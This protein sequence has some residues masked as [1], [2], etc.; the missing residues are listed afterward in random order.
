MLSKKMEN[1]LNEQVN[2]ELFSAYLYLSMV[3]YFVSLG[4]PGFAQWMRVQTQEELFHG[5]KMY[6]H[7]NQ[8]GGRVILRAIDAPVAEWVAPL[9]A[10]E[11]AYDHEK[12]I[13][14]SINKL[15]DLARTSTTMRPIFSCSGT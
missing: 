15:V 8:R 3:A 2:R 9:A 4:L 7:I 14:N 6:D 13:T 1:A 5:M 10:F 12:F 11:A